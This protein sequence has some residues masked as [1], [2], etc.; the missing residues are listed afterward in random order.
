V[1]L[2]MRMRERPAAKIMA[3]LPVEQAARVSFLMSGMVA[4]G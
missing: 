4:S 1:A 3:L 2:F